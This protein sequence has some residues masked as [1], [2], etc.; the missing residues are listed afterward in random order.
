MCQPKGTLGRAGSDVR[1]GGALDQSQ[2]S[3]CSLATLGGRPPVYSPDKNNTPHVAGP[4]KLRLSQDTNYNVSAMHS[5]QM[6]RK[7]DLAERHPLMMNMGA[8]LDAAV[9][10]AEAPKVGE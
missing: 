1:V 7:P 9:D 4:G 2:S 10:K 8:M 3:M 6:A 5:G